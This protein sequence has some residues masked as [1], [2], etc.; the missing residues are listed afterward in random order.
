MIFGWYIPTRPDGIYAAVVRNFLFAVAWYFHKCFNLINSC[1]VV[2]NF[3]LVASSWVT[4]TLG[5]RRSGQ[6]KFIGHIWI[7]IS[8]SKIIVKLTNDPKWTEIVVIRLLTVHGCPVKSVWILPIVHWRLNLIWT[9]LALSL[10]VKF[11]AWC[12][13]FTSWKD[14][15]LKQGLKSQHGFIRTDFRSM[16]IHKND[17][18]T[19]S[20]LSLSCKRFCF[21]VAIWFSS[22]NTSTC[23][24]AFAKAFSKSSQ[25]SIWHCWA[26]VMLSSVI[27]NISFIIRQSGVEHSLKYAATKFPKLTYNWSGL[28][29]EY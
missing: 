25:V 14:L 5:Q 23:S 15:F 12:K 16:D 29:F 8:V 13:E 26:K 10:V 6:S 1:A 27:A 20:C 18:R 3:I 17:K 28:I 19:L 24:S 9:C 22:A 4:A 11:L 21:W 7:E 2:V